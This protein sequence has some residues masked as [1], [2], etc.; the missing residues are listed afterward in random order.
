MAKLVKDLLMFKRI[1]FKLQLT[2]LFSLVIFTFAS[3]PKTFFQQD[4]WQFFGAA[5]SAIYSSHPILN[6]ILP[7]GGQLTHFYPLAKL[8]ILV[9]YALFKTNFASYAL[10]SLAMHIGN[11]ILVYILVKR[12]TKKELFAFLT[13]A[14]FL[15]NSFSH[16]ALTWVLA[17]ITTLPATFF[18]LLSLIFYT[19]YR[20]FKAQRYFIFSVVSLLISLL[21][22]EIGIFMFVL[23]PIFLML[24][25]NNL[26][27]KSLKKPITLLFLVGGLYLFLRIFFL[28]FDLRSP[29]PEPGD[30]NMPPLTTLAYRVIPV[31]LKGLAQS[32]FSYEFLIG[33]SDR[34][35]YLAYPQFFLPNGSINDSISQT[36]VLDLVCYILA[37]LIL[38][39]FLFMFFYLKQ[40]GERELKL[41]TTI[42]LFLMLTS[43]LP[44]VFIPGRPGYFSIFEPRNLYIGGIGTGLAT[45]LFF[46]VIASMLIKNSGKKMFLILI[47]SLPVLILHIDKIK[48]DLWD[49]EKVGQIRKSLLI[50]LNEEY[51]QLPE[52][53]VIFTD[54]DR[55]YYG[56][57]E[58]EKILPVQSGFGRMVLIW[59]QDKEN[60]PTCL[61]E[62]QFLHDLVS[63]GYK[64]CEGRGLGYFRKYQ[65]LLEEIKE[66]Y[67]SPEDV[68]SYQWNGGTNEFLNFT[69]KVRERLINDL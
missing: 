32:F 65:L 14:F 62:Q 23:L 68:I 11:G 25:K 50:T 39:I 36:I 44:F 40:K 16:Q 51:P 42:I 3:F 52:K 49:L 60:F 6:T 9:E 20:E 53:V 21:F 47:F 30:M 34:L 43:F 17:A 26:S 63:Q 29:Q 56:L 38:L 10:L 46:Y 7:F 45:V 18:I 28:F 35:I 2:A 67:F 13:T 55:P 27:L 33:V 12:L 37:I 15:I 19:Y 1:P 69:P 22:K 61:Y 24:D 31:P 41:S 8:L 48:S 66:G 5:I 59:Y 64:Y 4:E 54:S 58:K 57:P